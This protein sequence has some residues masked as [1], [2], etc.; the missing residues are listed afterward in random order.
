MNELVE[1]ESVVM[2]KEKSLADKEAE[3]RKELQGISSQLEEMASAKAQVVDLSKQYHVMTET[4]RG[5]LSTISAKE[6]EIARK[7][8]ALEK[9]E[10]KIKEIDTR[11]RAEHN[12]MDSKLRQL[13]EKEKT[14]E[15]AGAGGNLRSSKPSEVER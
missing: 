2:A 8:A 3:L 10:E 14:V 12:N 11:L 13:L 15:A 4:T 7:M 5:K 1:K 6:D 9:R